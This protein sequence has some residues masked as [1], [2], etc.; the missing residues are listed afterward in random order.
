MSDKY[1]F[2]DY[3]KYLCLKPGL[4][5][6]LMALFFLRPLILKFST[7]Q[8][9]RGAKSAS[10][11]KLYDLAYPDHF[12]FF[13]AV[14][15]A[16]PA[17]MLLVSYAKRIPG[18][19]ERMQK[20]WCNGL[21]YLG[22]TAILNVLVVFLP[23]F[24]GKIHAVHVYGWIQLGILILIMGYLYKSERLRDAFADFPVETEDDRNQAKKA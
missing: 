24:M 20:I 23:I 8:R 5:F 10:V 12:I 16:I 9:G 22:L 3:D 18:A 15:A 21:K 2:K 7:I 19:S 4:E 13:L 1:T 14:M 6:W 17:I 11:S